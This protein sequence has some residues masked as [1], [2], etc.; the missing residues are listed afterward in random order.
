MAGSHGQVYVMD[1]GC[2][3]VLAG[4]RPQDGDPVTVDRDPS[5]E[6]LDLPGSVIGTYEYM[7]PEQA[8]ALS[9]RIDEQ[10]DVYLLG[11]IL[12]ELLTGLPPH[13]GNSVA[14]TLRRANEGEVED[15][16][17]AA[18]DA[19]LPPALCAIAMRALQR[20][21]ADRHASVA[22]LQHEVERVLRGGLWFAEAS[23][24]AGALVVREGDAA[25]AA[26]IITR[27]SCAVFR[28]VDGQRVPLRTLGP[29]DVFGETAIFT[30]RERT[31]S[32][33][34]VEEMT[35]MVVT[36]ES[37]ER[38]MATRWVF[39]FV[40]SLAERFLELEAE[41]SAARRAAEPR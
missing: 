21:P 34:T 39:P 29:G 14:D 18:G 7:A 27:G 35:A 15:P 32:V 25:D 17:T 28:T 1:W 23:F 26:Y 40:R 6:A 33:E 3:L 22:E 19:K 11:G 37:L 36:R 16:Q 13:R 10:T 2:A 24:P 38:E 4:A 9:A 20:R 31:A 8:Q 12:Y 41:L 5:H 30:S